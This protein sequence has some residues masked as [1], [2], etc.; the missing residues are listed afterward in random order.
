MSTTLLYILEQCDMYVMQYLLQYVFTH[1]C[2]MSELY[3]ML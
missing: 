2:T 3:G 1:M